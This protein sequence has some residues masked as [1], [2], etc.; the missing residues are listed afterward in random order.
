M[1]TNKTT[2]MKH[3]I[4]LNLILTGLA[5]IAGFML[6]A[7]TDDLVTDSKS[8]YSLFD[9]SD[10]METQLGVSVN[11][12]AVSTSEATRADEPNEEPSGDT[13]IMSDFEKTVDNIWVFQYGDDG[14]LVIKP[15][16]YTAKESEIEG[17][18]H[19]LLKPVESTIYVVTNVNSD[20][21]ASSENDITAKFMTTEL[22]LASTLP[23]PY[24]IYNLSDDA[25]EG[26]IPMQGYVDEVTPV[27]GGDVIIVPVERMYAKVKVRVIID[28][29]LEPYE[30]SINSVYAQN[31]PWY[32]QIGTLYDK[33]VDS[34]D[35]VYPTTADDWVTRSMTTDGKGN[36]TDD[37]NNTPLEEEGETPYEYV[38][39]I[40]ENIQGEVSVDEK[41]ADAKVDNLPD[42]GHPTSIVVDIK[43]TD[44]KGAEAEASYTVYPGGNNYNNFNIRRNQVYRVTMLLGA[45]ETQHTPSANCIVGHPGKTISF[46]PYYRVETGGGYDF[47]DYLDPTDESKTI[48]GYKILWQTENCIGDNSDG[49]LVTFEL[50]EAD[51]VHSKFYVQVKAVGNAVIAAYN[52][53][54]C[55]GDILWSWHIWVTKEDPTNISNAVTY[56]TYDWD[57]SGIYGYGNTAGRARVPGYGMMSCNLGALSSE[58]ASDAAADKVETYGLLY[59]WGRKDPFPALKT[60]AKDGV[61][62]DFYD[63]TEATTENLYDNENKRIT[64]MTA[65]TDEDLLFHSVTGTTIKE[66]GYGVDFTIKN[67][68]VFM[69]GTDLANQKTATYVGINTETGSTLTNTVANYTFEGDWME[70]H[71]EKLWGATP[72]AEA[73]LTLQVATDSR[74]DAIHLRNTYGTKSI[75]DPCPYGWRV[76]PPDQ[77]LGFTKT[78]MNPSSYDEIN[79]SDGSGSANNAHYVMSLYIQDWKKGL[80]S[81]FPVQGTRCPD[82]SYLRPNRCGNYHNATSDPSNTFQRVNILHVHNDYSNFHIFEAKFVTYYNKATAGPIRC[83]RDTK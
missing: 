17:T 71:D 16:Y 8:A 31:C 36:N 13:E 41:D 47:S 56:Y 74:E 50:D 61:S 53:D 83:V 39:Y 24:T 79:T 77:W 5:M 23:T 80:E 4:Y 18:W 20:T 32:C 64:G 54:K 7:C 22:L 78:G 57:E 81:Y 44:S 25:T 14:N 75:Y 6:V 65:G 67:P 9:E 49:S 12:F 70:N 34:Q 59:Q 45:P 69:C 60:R 43:Y 29:L 2:V 3:K 1:A 30:P 28:K 40:P 66:K 26:H 51:P 11:E 21:W 52:D 68:T 10:I 48:K 62:G 63:Y 82:G 35:K 58:P 37:P 38:V 46:E 42:D 76:S 33:T 55:E 72:V 27:S 73:T 19:V 15:R